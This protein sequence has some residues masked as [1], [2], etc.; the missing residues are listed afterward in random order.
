M[1][2]GP[3]AGRT[4]VTAVL[5][6]GGERAFVTF[7][8]AGR[9]RPAR[10]IE[11]LRPRAVVA[12]ARRPRRSCRTGA[13]VYAGAGHRDAERHAS[14]LPAGLARARALLVNRS[15]ALR[16]TGERDADDA[17]LVLAETVETAVVTLRRGGRRRGRGRRAR[18]GRARPAV[19]AR[20]TTGAGDLFIAAYVWGDLAGLPLAERL[21][22]GG[23]L[24]RPL[25]ADGHGGRERSHPGRA[26]ARPGELDPAIVHE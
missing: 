11:R 23:R 24:R 8:P 17:A 3:T 26:R 5:P 7:E 15:E 2:A 6:V 16:L 22:A 12:D 20:D 14:Q 13:S 1:C 9:D 21:R 4:P 19:E 10:S 18:H 25:G